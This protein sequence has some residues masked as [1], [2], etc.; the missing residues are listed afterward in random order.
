MRR[1]WFLMVFAG[2]SGCMWFVPSDIK[3]GIDFMD[4]VIQ[5]GVKEAKDIESITD[6]TKARAQAMRAVRALRRLSPHSDNLKRWIEGKE[7]ASD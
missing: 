3:T 5:V 4:T 6:D 2:L 1:F 7:S